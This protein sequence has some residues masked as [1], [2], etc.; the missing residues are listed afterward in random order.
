MLG[1]KGNVRL[2]HRNYLPFESGKITREHVCAQFG[3]EFGKEP[4]EQEVQTLLLEMKKIKSE[5]KEWMGNILR[6]QIFENARQVQMKAPDGLIVSHIKEVGSLYINAPAADKER[7][8]A[9]VHW[10]F[11]GWFSLQKN[12]HEE[13]EKEYLAFKGYGYKQEEKKE[14]QRKPKGFIADICKAK[15][16]EIVNVFKKRCVKSKSGLYVKDS[17]HMEQG[18]NGGRKVQGKRRE[19]GQ[20]Y[21]DYQTK[22]GAPVVLDTDP[23]P[24]VH[25][26]SQELI[27][28]NK[29]V[30]FEKVLKEEY[31]HWAGTYNSGL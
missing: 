28:E 17:G 1:N 2:F 22:Q 10:T 26:V 5:C 31:P 19:V 9:E 21:S 20:F 25:S 4:N 30:Y 29:N 6:R 16:N 23:M 15:R 8:A 14:G 3:Q 18:E 12:Y 27:N 24:S 7:L 11:Y 13:L